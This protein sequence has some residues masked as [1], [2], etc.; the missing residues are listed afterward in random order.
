MDLGLTLVHKIR[1]L[2]GGGSNILILSEVSAASSA[3]AA[4]AAAAAAMNSLRDTESFVI[5]FSFWVPLV[6]VSA[7]P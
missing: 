6:A 4:G 3:G 5:I 1:I 7:T 2:A